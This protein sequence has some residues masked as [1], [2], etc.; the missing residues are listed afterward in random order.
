M[1]LVID[2]PDQAINYY[3]QEVDDLLLE[4]TPPKKSTSTESKISSKSHLYSKTI[5]A[6][7]IEDLTISSIDSF[8]NLK[9]KY[10]ST[11]K[12][13]IGLDGDA[14]KKC[15]KIVRELSCKKGL[16][17]LVGHE[18]ILECIIKWFSLQY[19]GK[20][21]RDVNFLQFLSEKIPKVVKEYTIAIPVTHLFIEDSFTV[22]NITFDVY[23][24]DLFDRIENYDLENMDDLKN[25]ESFIQG[26][27]IIRKKYQG[28]VFATIKLKAEK[29]RAIE[30]AKN[31][32]RNA[33]A[34]LNLFSPAAFFPEIPNYIGLMGQSSVPESHVFLFE[35]ELPEI[36]SSIEEYPAI[37]WT[38]DEK[39][40][41]M[42]QR[43]GIKMF[44]DLCANND[45]TPFEELCFTCI[46]YYTKAISAREVHDR[47]VFALVSIE[48]LL[49]K[50]RNEKW[51][52]ETGQL[53]SVNSA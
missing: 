40:M 36:I 52:P 8:G 18:F 6:K 37:T 10:F 11:S 38:I 9:S 39:F 30:I 41:S 5:S 25:K 4:L 13:Q 51:T 26:M 19:T 12:G 14:F 31:E 43:S 22:G 49:L 44:S 35:N 1:K 3:N 21:K 42:M 7:E 20:I 16:R 32:A 34:I 15:Y 29:N 45:Q 50:D 53:L 27:T 28:K 24:E 46:K 2:I 33:L 47:L 48:T 17:E 23:K